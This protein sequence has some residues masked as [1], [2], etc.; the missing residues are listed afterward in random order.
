MV[1]IPNRDYRF[2]RMMDKMV[3]SCA[4]PARGHNV[5]IVCLSGE[6][7]ALFTKIIRYIDKEPRPMGLNAPT[8]Y[9]NHHGPPCLIYTDTESSIS[10]LSEPEDFNGRRFRSI[11]IVSDVFKLTVD[12]RRC[13]GLATLSSRAAVNLGIPE[14]Y[15]W[16]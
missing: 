16:R 15:D 4:P 11:Y 2:K 3:L 10:I 9:F 1:D 13:L 8:S 14:T 6:E 7:E 12:T 5:G